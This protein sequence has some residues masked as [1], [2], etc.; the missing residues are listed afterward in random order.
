MMRISRALALAGIDSRRKCEVHVRNGAVSVNGEVVR[1]LGRQV[2]PE[3]DEI[4][5]R[6]RPVR[7]EKYIYY[8]LYKPVG[9]TTTAG[10]PHAK[11]TVYHLMP[12]HLVPRTRQM[13]TPRIRVFPVG[14]LDQDSAGLLLMTNDGAAA[15]R[16][17]H[18]RFRVEKWYLVRLNRA[19]EA[20]DLKRALDGVVLSDGPAKAEKL[21]PVSRR[22][23]RL[24]IREGRNREIR[25][26]FGKLGYEV[27]ELCRIAFGPITLGNLGPGQG[28]FLTPAEVHL[29]KGN[30]PSSGRASTQR[31][32][33]R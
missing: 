2:D 3:A 31:I 30:T 16:L 6:S 23:V 25:R 22:I 5:F 4:L 24:M 18:P 28:R 21:Q 26:L 32:S 11:K 29:L 8:L 20:P 27:T 1:D 14:R 10:D 7:F 12:K 15:H 9:Y 33:R 13:Q 17:T 19:L